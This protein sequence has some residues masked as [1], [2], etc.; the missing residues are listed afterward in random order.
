MKDEAREIR[1]NI[2]SLSMV[3]QKR[4][5]ENDIKL[6]GQ[7][8]RGL[9][10][11]V[12]W[13]SSELDSSQFEPDLKDSIAIS[14]QIDIETIEKSIEEADPQGFS[15]RTVSGGPYARRLLI[16][17]W[18][19]N[20]EDVEN[21][22]R[23]L[24]RSFALMFLGSKPFDL[25]GND[26]KLSASLTG[27]VEKLEQLEL[28]R[29]QAVPIGGLA[30]HYRNLLMRLVQLFAIAELDEPDGQVIEVDGSDVIEGAIAGV[31]AFLGRSSSYRSPDVEDLTQA[32]GY[33]IESPTDVLYDWL[34]SGE[35]PA[36][37]DEI[38]LEVS[39]RSLTE[40][41]RRLGTSLDR[42]DQATLDVISNSIASG[43][44]RGE[45]IGFALIADVTHRFFDPDGLA[46]FIEPEM[47]DDEETE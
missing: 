22:L 2:D 36:G 3:S 6:E 26:A 44:S 35:D 45:E 21:A 39:L 40:L 5:L 23:A 12:D 34:Y 16:L 24:A 33:A 9:N 8:Q 41:R 42:S 25:T 15:L 13:V 17:P 29:G 27:V 1:K 7:R 38:A 30:T 28:E 43:R 31:N 11:F 47:N 32:Q 14:R 10:A 46:S 37:E 19:R 18:A 4:I 20:A